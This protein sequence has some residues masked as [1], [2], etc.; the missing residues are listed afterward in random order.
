MSLLILFKLPKSLIQ[1]FSSKACFQHALRR[2]TTSAGAP[3][4]SNKLKLKELKA[5]FTFTL[6][7][8]TI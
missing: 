6:Y 7:K 8:R 1:P 2:K 5:A 4:E 3:I